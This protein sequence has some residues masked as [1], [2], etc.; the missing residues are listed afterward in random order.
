VMKETI[1]DM[2]SKDPKMMIPIKED[3]LTLECVLNTLDGIK[4]L[5]DAVIVFTTNDINSLD[6]ALIRPGRIDRKIEMKLVTRDIIKEMLRHYYPKIKKMGALDSF[7]GAL[8]P[9]SVQQICEISSSSDEC[10][11][12]ICSL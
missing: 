12:K 11:R 3:E 6:P 4:E 8:S 1:M 5:H 9:A 2:F 10:I 7:N